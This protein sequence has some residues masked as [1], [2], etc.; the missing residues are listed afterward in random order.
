[1][2]GVSVL[3]FIRV[4]TQAASYSYRI[5]HQ[6]K[7]HC[8]P[9]KQRCFSTPSAS[10]L[11]SYT[12]NRFFFPLQWHFLQG[13]EECLNGTQQYLP[14]FCY[15]DAGECLEKL[16]GLPESSTR[17]PHLK[18]GP[19]RGSCA[20]AFAGKQPGLHGRITRA[21]C[22]S[23]DSISKTVLSGPLRHARAAMP[24]GNNRRQQPTQ[25]RLPTAPS[26][27]PE[28]S[29]DVRC[30]AGAVTHRARHNGF[31]GYGSPAT[32]QRC[33]AH[34]PFRRQPPSPSHNSWG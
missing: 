18:A 9:H 24:S 11:H 15:R 1:M 30:Q 28:R 12:E 32:T 27:P 34:T 23:S 21:Q 29:Q 20:P 14:Q 33:C 10:H 6:V 17:S 4:R 8:T 7:T 16:S 3:V 2:T 13:Q 22:C 25:S 19:A 26:S 5:Q 31:P